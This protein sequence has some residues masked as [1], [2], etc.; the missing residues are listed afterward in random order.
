MINSRNYKKLSHT[1]AQGINATQLSIN[2]Q[3]YVHQVHCLRGSKHFTR[4]ISL[5]KIYPFGTPIPDIISIFPYF[6]V[7]LY[8][9]YDGYGGSKMIIVGKCDKRKCS[10]TLQIKHCWSHDFYRKMNVEKEDNSTNKYVLIITT[11]LGR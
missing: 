11:R 4:S 10:Y 9:K 2:A 8:L 3:L 6:L 7:V 5:V 1:H